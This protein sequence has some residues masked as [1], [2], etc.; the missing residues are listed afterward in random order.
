MEPVIGIRCLHLDLK[1]QP[2]TPQRLLSLLELLAK[3]RY[4]A[5][6]VEWEDM[7]PWTCDERFR[8]ETAYKPEELKAFV[9]KAKELGID[10]I[11]LVQ[12]LGHLETPLKFPEY[13]HLR[14]VPDRPDVLNPLAEGA[15]MDCKSGVSATNLSRG[16]KKPSRKRGK[17]PP[18]HTTSGPAPPTMDTNTLSL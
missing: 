1:G 9:A 7:F 5:V 12:C 2:P 13:A 14:E 6:L 16:S 4:N 8:C 18:I 17:P 3:A 11:P 15:K 10:I